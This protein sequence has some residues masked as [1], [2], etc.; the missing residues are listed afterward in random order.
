MDAEGTN[1][2]KIYSDVND[3][4]FSGTFSSR[5]SL[6]YNNISDKYGS[7]SEIGDTM[8]FR[9]I[10]G[11]WEVTTLNRCR[12]Q[13]TKIG[14]LGNS[15]TWSFRPLSYLTELSSTGVFDEI[16]DTSVSHLNVNSNGN[17]PN[18]FN[19]STTS[20]GNSREVA[21]RDGFKFRIEVKNKKVYIE[22]NFRI[23]INRPF[24]R[25]DN[26]GVSPGTFQNFFWKH[27]RENIFRI[28]EIF[29]PNLMPEFESTW[30]YVS[31]YLIEGT[32][33]INLVDAKISISRT[34]I[35]YLIFKAESTKTIVKVDD[36]Q[37]SN[38][39]Y[40]DIW[41]PASKYDAANDFSE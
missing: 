19:F 40:M 41:V 22:G 5:L 35:I 26:D 32:N 15:I 13:V 24:S 6:S 25:P 21:N 2:S 9:K 39:L 8:I 27:Q 37:I 23:V 16:T 4:I 31:G 12:K 11:F 10:S 28:G 17:P 3:A 30:F 33:E 18:K 36:Y 34:G 38:I 14:G 1:T 20:V 29:D 7:K